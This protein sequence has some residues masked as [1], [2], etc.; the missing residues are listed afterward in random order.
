MKKLLSVF[1]LIILVFSLTSCLFLDGDF[2]YPE[3]GNEGSGDNIYNYEINAGENNYIDI[4]LEGQNNV[5]AASK[6]LLSTVSVYCT[7]YEK[8]SYNSLKGREYSSAGAGVIYKIDKERGDAYVITNYHVVY[9]AYCDTKNKISNEISLFL[10]GSEYTDYAID[11]TYVGG[12]MYYD[13]AVLKV[14]ASE[15]L[16]KS[17]AM[18]AE[19]ADSDALT[20]LDTVVA[21]G[22]PEGRGISATVGY[23]NVDSE[24]ITITMTTGNGYSQGIELRCMRIDAAVNSGNSGGGLYNDEGD[25]I[26]VVNAKMVDSTVDNIGYAIPSNVARA[27][28]DNIIYYCDGTDKENVYRC[29]LGVEVTTVSANAVYDET[30]G[31]IKK[32]ESIKISKV[33]ESGAVNG[34]LA[35]DD[36]INTITIGNRTVNITRLHHVIDTMLDARVGEKVVFNVTRN[37]QAMDVEIFITENML[38]EY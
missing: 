15:V 7:F 29:L 24:Y 36:I 33:E 37:G 32:V 4:T 12:S 9:D 30:T 26:G 27:I 5:A 21:V 16:M 14:E 25:L 31:E 3:T 20:I 17:A 22:N 2:F 18:A 8:S 10:Y 13:L 28:A 34:I 19:I 1:L 35:V 38:T 23:I 6:A 11:A